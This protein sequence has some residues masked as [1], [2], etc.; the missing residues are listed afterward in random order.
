MDLK[1]KE[2]KA[3]L[4]Q[5]FKVLPEE[6]STEEMIKS[7]RQY[8]IKLSRLLVGHTRDSRKF[9]CQ[10]MPNTQRAEMQNTEKE[11]REQTGQNCFDE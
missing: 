10:D 6:K 2:R 1:T 4:Q 7:N 3:F 11:K 9:K 8:K 5:C